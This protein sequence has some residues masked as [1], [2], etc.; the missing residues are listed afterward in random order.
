MDTNKSI[1]ISVGIIVV[2][3]IVGIIIYNAGSSEVP[4][5]NTPV[6]PTTSNKPVMPKVAPKVKTST[7]TSPTYS[8]APV[9][10]D[11]FSV[12]FVSP[13]SG[14][15]GTTVTVYG[16][17]F[18]LK[19]NTVILNK[20]AK[21]YI[22]NLSS[23]NGQT[24]TFTIPESAVINGKTTPLETGTYDISVKDARGVESKLISF[25]ITP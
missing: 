15:V 18:S 23:S 13:I 24:I 11:T 22:Y 4:T 7:T 16:N 25:I 14:P 6:S 8:S 12:D 10:L 9:V 20:S 21:I 19:G 1:A 2:C 3:V 17:S 5:V